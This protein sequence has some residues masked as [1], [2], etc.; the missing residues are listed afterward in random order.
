[1]LFC[2]AAE[3]DRDRPD[4]HRAERAQRADRGAEGREQE[5]G[6]GQRDHEPVPPRHG[7]EHLLLLNLGN[8]HMSPLA[9]PRRRDRLP[10]LYKRDAARKRT[11]GPHTWSSTSVSLGRAADVPICAI[12]S[13]SRP[14]SD[15]ICRGET[16]GLWAADCKTGRAPTRCRRSE[17]TSQ[18]CC[19]ALV[20]V[21]RRRRWRRPAMQPGR[22]EQIEEMTRADRVRG[23]QVRL[24]PAGLDHRP[25]MGK[26]VV[27][28]VLPAGRREAATSSST[29]PPPTCSPTATATTS[30]SA[31][32]SPS[33]PRSPTSTP[34][35]R[36]PGTRGSR[37]STATA[38][39]PRRAS[40]STPTRART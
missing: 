23:H 32:R 20:R 14:G 19:R 30:A 2:S 15:R 25:L 36:C 22:A 7:L 11:T 8:R 27:V 33:S 10:N 5:P 34:S 18:Q 12:M 17:A 21:R 13:Y 9:F 29:A 35:R 31:P 24:L 38:T 26:G 39:T 40:C 37:A 3:Q 4:D 6:I 1:M 28:V 16:D